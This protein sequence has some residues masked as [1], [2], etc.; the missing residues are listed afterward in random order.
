MSSISG[1]ETEILHILGPKKK[2]KP[3]MNVLTNSRKTFKKVLGK[4]KDQG[5]ASRTLL[6]PVLL[7]SGQYLA[8]FPGSLARG[9][10]CFLEPVPWPLGIDDTTKQSPWENWEMGTWLQASLLPNTLDCTEPSLRA[11]VW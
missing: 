10:E 6:G 4:K 11:A 3:R 2:K 5:E 1:Q 9:Q 8:L 7:F